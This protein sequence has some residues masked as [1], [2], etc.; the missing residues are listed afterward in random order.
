MQETQLS[1]SSAVS[2]HKKERCKNNV[3]TSTRQ[4]RNYSLP[5]V[6][7]L[8]IDRKVLYQTNELIS[9]YKHDPL[10]LKKVVLSTRAQYNC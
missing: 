8:I 2:S 1:N 4:K 5:F 7:F 9:C 10:S 6:K 3:W